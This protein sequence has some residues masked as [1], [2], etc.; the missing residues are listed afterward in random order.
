MPR[1]SSSGDYESINDSW[2]PAIAGT[3]IDPTDWNT[4]YNDFAT[5]FGT[6]SLDRTGAGGMLADLQVNTHSALFGEIVTPANPAANFLKLYVKD[7]AGITKLAGLD[8][9]GTE[10]IFGTG[11]GTVTSVSVVTANGVSGSVATATTTPAITLTLGAITPTSV[12]SV[13]LSGSA[14]PTLAVTG[15][16]TISGSNTGDQT[17]ITGNAGTATALQ[18]ARTI[19]G[20]SFNGTANI[21]V[22]SATGGFTISGGDLALGANNITM[23]GSLAVTGTRVTKGWFTDIESTNSATIGGVA[24]SGTGGYLRT[25]AATFITSLTGPLHIGGIGVSSDITY[26]TTTGVGD[27]TD[28]HIFTGGNNGA[29]TFATLAATYT[30]IGSG[31]AYSYGG[32]FQNIQM[33]TTLG[34]LSG[35]SSN[36]AEFQSNVYFNGTNY[37]YRTTT[38]A[39][40]IGFGS[41]QMSVTTAP[42]G[43]AGATATLTEHL[44]LANDGTLTIKPGGLSALV[45]APVAT[46]VNFL[47]INQATTG[48]SPNI[49]F[50]G[51][52]T[53]INALLVA[54]GTG[55][56]VNAGSNANGSATTANLAI[57]GTGRIFKNSSQKKYKY[58]IEDL[59]PSIAT[60]IVNNLHPIWYRSNLPYDMEKNNNWS[61]YGLLSDEV[62][63][64]DPRL[65][66]W[67]Y[68][69]LDNFD[70]NGQPIMGNELI[71]TGVNY[72]K[73][74]LFALIAFREQISQM[75]VEIEE[76]KASKQ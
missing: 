1:N 54:K 38:T 13:V 60:K 63:A 20:V 65:A 72:D 32:S 30:I 70:E 26:Q 55:V 2:A 48:N 6:N 47:G 56:L 61:Y 44:L 28:L 66:H 34:I 19:G 64:I 71:P 23:S 16:S 53:N 22:A 40:K 74:S 17:N 15:T 42:S 8:S 18:N 5:T 36:I 3:P 49:T 9:A 10:S 43:T 52:D 62:A 7:V 24:A 73:I 33:G 11:V 4:Q 69:F 57:D 51:S 29:T 41:G 45:I 21:T 50:A 39:S 27:G 59:D 46:A 14:T 12:N 68:D 58:D 75:R 76:L 31:A 67:D 35:T 25:T 37:I